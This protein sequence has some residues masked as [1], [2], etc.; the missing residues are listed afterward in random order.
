[1][2]SLTDNRDV[3]V[4]GAAV[5][6]GAVSCGGVKG[7]DG[8]EVEPFEPTDESASCEAIRVREDEDGVESDGADESDI[9]RCC[10]AI[11]DGSC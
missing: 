8:V 4:S 10:G 11:V 7:E 3:A 1:M 2:H 9:V 5:V 6:V